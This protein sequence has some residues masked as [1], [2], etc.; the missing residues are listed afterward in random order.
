MYIKSDQSDN[1][2]MVYNEF[3]QYEL[4]PDLE[5]LVSKE[6]R[7]EMKQIIDQKYNKL[8]LPEKQFYRHSTVRSCATGRQKQVEKLSSRLKT[9]GQISNLNKDETM[10]DNLLS[11]FKKD[12]SDGDSFSATSINV[13]R[14]NHLNNQTKQGKNESDSRYEHR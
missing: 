10:S 2:N 5:H 14:V 12:T 8:E 11:N 7:E 6:R 1:N 4:H 3:E 9:E 13:K